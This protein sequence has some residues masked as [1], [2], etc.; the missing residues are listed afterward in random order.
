MTRPS[1]IDE[2]LAAFL[3]GPVS[4]HV[5]SHAADKVP[6]LVRA[7]G[8][9]VAPDRRHV[10]LF[11]AR[12]KS[13]AVIEALRATRVVAAVFTL[14]S[15]HR[16]VQLKGSD[17]EVG[18]PAA[19]DLEKVGRYIEAF[20]REIDPLGYRPEMGRALLWL[21]AADLVALSFTPS[22]AFTQTPG[23]GAGALLRAA[24]P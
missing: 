17:A 12:S 4:I 3:C 21:D 1:L 19:G 6:V 14:P 2:E 9:R 18:P 13:E 23:P 16:S 20:A 11:L 24:A 10:A 15:S 5:A 22:A 7:S 8:C